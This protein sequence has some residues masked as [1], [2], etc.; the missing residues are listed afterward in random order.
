MQQHSSG[1]LPPLGEYKFN[2]DVSLHDN[3]ATIAIILRDRFGVI[4]G[5]WSNYFYSSN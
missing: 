2:F 3:Q 5:A 4:M 1:K